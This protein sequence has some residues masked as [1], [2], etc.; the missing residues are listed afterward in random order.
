M[1]G[2]IQVHPYFLTKTNRF[3]Y[4]GLIDLTPWRRATPEGLAQTLLAASGER[5]RASLAMAAGGLRWDTDI[6]ATGHEYSGKNRR[7]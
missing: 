5:S 2:T 6:S 1:I 3:F 4:E 7:M